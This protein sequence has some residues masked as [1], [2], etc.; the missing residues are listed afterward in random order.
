[1][2]RSVAL[3]IGMGDYHESRGNGLIAQGDFALLLIASMIGLTLIV[4]PGKDLAVHA[5]AL[6]CTLTVQI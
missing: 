3:D 2:N 6:C 1:M 5:L 4:C